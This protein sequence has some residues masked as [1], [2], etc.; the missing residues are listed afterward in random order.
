METAP[1]GYL[2]TLYRT[3]RTENTLTLH[4][5]NSNGLIQPEG[6]EL[7]HKDIINSFVQ[8]APRNPEAM[9]IVLNL[10]NIKSCR[11]YTP[12]QAQVIDIKVNELNNQS[13]IVIPED[14]F[15]GYAVLELTLNDAE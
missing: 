1:Q 5:F 2:T 13:K 12:E 4:L 8:D 9:E 15:A 14:T 11:L 3:G 10:D 7:S 6:T